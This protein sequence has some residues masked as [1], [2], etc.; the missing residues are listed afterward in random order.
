MWRRTLEEDCSNV[1]SVSPV[2]PVPTEDCE[3]D[4]CVDVSSSEEQSDEN[5]PVGENN[6]FSTQ[7][8]KVSVTQENEFGSGDSFKRET[9]AT[10]V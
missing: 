6:F 4:D 1:E 8:V 9:G 3:S 10:L 5:Q 2:D 7:R